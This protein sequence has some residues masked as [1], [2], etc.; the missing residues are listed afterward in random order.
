MRPYVMWRYWKA[1]GHHW[2]TVCAHFSL[3]LFSSWWPCPLQVAGLYLCF[4]LAQ[5]Q[6]GW[7]RIRPWCWLLLLADWTSSGSRQVRRGEFLPRAHTQPPFLLPWLLCR[8]SHGTSTRVAGKMGCLGS[9]GVGPLDSYWGHPLKSSWEWH[10]PH[11]TS[12]VLWM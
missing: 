6:W 4:S 3:G 12:N 9:T 5:P 10:Q 11:D 1:G 8:W 7:C 2:L